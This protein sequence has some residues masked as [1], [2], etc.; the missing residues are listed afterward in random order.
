MERRR[1]KRYTVPEIY[2]NDI[3]FR[4]KEGSGEFVSAKPLD[5]SLRGVKIKR[6]SA[7]PLGSVIGCLISLPESLSGEVPFSAK[8]VYCAEDK[9]E[10]GYVIGA[11][12]AQ[13][14]A[15]LWVNV[16]FRIHDFISRSL[17]VQ[18]IPSPLFNS[19]HT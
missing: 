5:V 16:F 11:E 4:I 14:S 19:F 7:L 3:A 6:Q 13:T 15:E 17:R 18:D 2:Q 1:G 9:A 10:G 12:I 8:V